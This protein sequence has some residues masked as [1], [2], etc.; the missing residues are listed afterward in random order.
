[1]LDWFSA[2]P[3]GLRLVR[4]DSTGECG[5]AIL[6]NLHSQINNQEIRLRARGTLRHVACIEPL[7]SV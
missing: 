6:M 2:R 1:M 3:N 7:Q 4:D 5:E